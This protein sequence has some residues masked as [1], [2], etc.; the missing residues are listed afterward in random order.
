MIE[1]DRRLDCSLRT[2]RIAR[3]AARGL[4]D[5]FFGLPAVRLFATAIPI[6]DHV[7]RIADE[8]RGV[9]SRSTAARSQVS[10]LPEFVRIAP[11]SRPKRLADFFS[12]PKNQK[13]VAM[14][15]VDFEI[16]L[17]H[18]EHHGQRSRCLP[19]G[20]A[21]GLTSEER[22]RIAGSIAT[23]QLGEQ[24]EGHTFLRAAKDFAQA[25]S[26]PALA[27]IVE[28]L[29]R[30][31]QGHAALLLAYMKDNDI[32]PKRT[33]WTDRW[34][35]RLR[36]LAGLELYLQVLISAELVG[37]VYYR[38]LERST[39][40]PKLK[41]LCRV[42]VSDELAH[43]GFE[44]QML[45]ALRARRAS[46]LRSLMRLAHQGFFMATAAVVWVTHGAV[47]R[48]SGY[49]ALTFLRACRSQYAFYLEPLKTDRAGDLLFGTKG[50]V[51]LRRDGIE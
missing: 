23:F 10:P 44:S 11:S 51:N 35:R 1:N 33:H 4:A 37:I 26:I 27:R 31:E 14:T 19:S 13:D 24:S 16:W 42:L 45:L 46:P 17:K 32:A 9:V 18:F 3:Q 2:R 28:L 20:L 6:G 43:V 41:I 15:R 8:A 12:L 49:R 22:R 34:F 25:Q 29:I 50:L 38:A 48:H 47:L 21:S 40:C 36:R 39:N 7:I 5:R 30:E